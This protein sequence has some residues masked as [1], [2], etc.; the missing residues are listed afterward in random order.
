MVE[1]YL[2]DMYDVEVF[3]PSIR[4]PVGKRNAWEPLFPMY[5]FCHVDPL[6]VDWPAIRWAPGLSYF[7]GV[8]QELVPVPEMVIGEIKERVCLW[9]ERASGSRF[10]PGDKVT[11]T[12]GP[13]AGLEA[14]F[15]RYVPA[16]QRCEVLLQIINRLARVEIPVEALGGK[17]QYHRVSSMA[18]A[19]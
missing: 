18:R 10:A 12:A 16:R 11:V 13:F 2:K 17:A 1:N 4:R 7:L 19:V 3:L 15:Q 14:I 9:N 6:A 5:I 8:N